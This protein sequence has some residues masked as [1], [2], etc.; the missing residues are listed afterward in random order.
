M[1]KLT[2]P[3]I[4]E[5]TSEFVPNPIES[6]KEKHYREWCKQLQEAIAWHREI[7]AYCPPTISNSWYICVGFLMQLITLI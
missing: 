2:P 4:L 3:P 7:L 5:P 1:P 6:L